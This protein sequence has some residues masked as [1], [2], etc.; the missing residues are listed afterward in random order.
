MRFVLAVVLAL[1]A[2]SAA[3]QDATPRERIIGAL[4]REGYER[5]TVSRTLLG[6]ERIVAR[7]EGAVREIVFNPVTGL[8]LRDYLRLLSGSRSGGGNER[9]GGGQAVGTGYDDEYEDDD[10]EDDDYEDDDEREDERD[11]S[12]PSENSGSS[13]DD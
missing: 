8:I 6:R 12:G 7:R 4:A 11:N 3:A 1:A 2:A 9:A 10:Y 13:K 5:F